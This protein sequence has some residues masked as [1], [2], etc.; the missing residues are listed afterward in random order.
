MSYEKNVS[1][2]LLLDFY[3]Q[4]LSDKQRETAELYYNEDLS[5]SEIAQLQNI[6]RP[7]VRDRLVKAEMILR[8]YESKL[9]L[10][11]RFTLMKEE[12]A[13]I[14]ELLRRKEAGDDIKTETILTRLS[15]LQ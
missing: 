11:E 2:S 4:M 5:L 7:G 8:D 3:G 9:G 14:A 10:L 15:N 13:E 12:I 1:I 6:T